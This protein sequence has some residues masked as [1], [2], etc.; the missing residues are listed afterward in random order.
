MP[1]RKGKILGCSHFCSWAGSVIQVV[2][3]SAANF[4]WVCIQ[5][6]ELVFLFYPGLHLPYIG[7]SYAYTHLP[8]QYTHWV[9]SAAASKRLYD[10]LL[11]SRYYTLEYMH[12]L[13]NRIRSLMKTCPSPSWA[14]WGDNKASKCSVYSAAYHWRLICTAQGLI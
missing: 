12:R 2:A 8:T 3:W 5:V 10:Y 9:Y 13:R 7:E 14:C 11:I 6:G 4:L 1:T